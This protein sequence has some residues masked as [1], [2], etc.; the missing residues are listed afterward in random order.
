MLSAVEEVGLAGAGLAGRVR[1]ALYKSGDEELHRM[2]DEIERESRAVHLVY[3]RDGRDETVR[4]LA[5][6]ITVLPDQVAYVHAVT[7]T[8]HNALTRLPDLYFADAQVREVLQLPAPEE[9]WLHRYWT[10]G[11]R[12]HNCVIGRHDAVVDFSSAAWKSTLLYVE[13]NMGGIGGLHLV[14]AAEVV[15]ERVVLPVLHRN[16]PALRL[17]RGYDMRQ[18]LRQELM[19]H[20]EAIGRTPRRICFVEPK[21]SGSGPDEQEAV[22]R[23]FH[24]HFE[25]EVCHADPAEL[26]LRGEEVCYQGAPIDL[27][28]RDYSV[29]DLLAFEREGGDVRPMRALFAQNRMVSSVAAELDQKSC[30][31]LLTDPELSA[32]HVPAHERQVCR[33]HLPWTRLLS[34]RRCRLPDGDTGDLLE[35]VRR[36]REHLVLKPNRAWGGQ[37]VCVGVAVTQSAWERSIDAALAD[38][39]RWVVQR[40]VN[41]PVGEFPVLGADGHVHVEP[42]FT[43]MGFAAS[44]DGLSVLA[45][46]SQKQVVNVANRGGLATLA[47]GHPP[48]RVA[49]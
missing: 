28:Y 9:A 20:M 10:P 43:V 15:I 34:E 1:K 38:Q 7:L 45:R 32:R 13:P 24:D 37:G 46:A 48:R 33:R 49:M 6:P 2:L 47:V 14:P 22:A 4:L 35:H 3:Q 25:V 44:R 40:L 12:E 5:L 41:I 31:E 29:E 42:F 26:E 30:F 27:A 18:L 21:Y 39:A 23:H 11:V 36:E 17:E 16:D 8:L 19:D